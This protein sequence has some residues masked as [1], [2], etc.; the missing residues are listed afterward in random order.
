MKGGILQFL[1]KLRVFTKFTFGLPS[2][3][4]N[5]WQSWHHEDF[6]DSKPV[7]KVIYDLCFQSYSCFLKEYLEFVMFSPPEIWSKQ[8]VILTDFEQILS[9]VMCRLEILDIKFRSFLYL[10]SFWGG[11]WKEMTKKSTQWKWK[12]WK[13]ENVTDWCKTGAKSIPICHQTLIARNSG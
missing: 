4:C 2:E 13:S 12:Q 5:L 8:H 11:V 3:L 1:S 7:W 6:L 10:I 9:Q